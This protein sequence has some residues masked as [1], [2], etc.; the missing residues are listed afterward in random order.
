MAKIKFEIKIRGRL[1]NIM[2]TKGKL[3]ESYD[4]YICQ[5]LLPAL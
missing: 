5:R 4:S 3:R 1:I 2:E